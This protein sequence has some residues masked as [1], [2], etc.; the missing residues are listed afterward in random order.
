MS[1]DQDLPLSNAAH[2]NASIDE[3]VD[4]LCFGGHMIRL[5]NLLNSR[6]QLSVASEITPALVR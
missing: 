5:E 4:Q 3:P 2:I 1:Y 6:Q